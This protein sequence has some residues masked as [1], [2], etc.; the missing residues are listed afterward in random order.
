M[1]QEDKDDTMTKRAARI[2][3]KLRLMK[4]DPKPQI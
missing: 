4:N 3:D 1:S 2:S